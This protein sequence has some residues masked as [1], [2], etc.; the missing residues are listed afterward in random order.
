[1]KSLIAGCLAAIA[2]ALGSSFALETLQQPSAH[3]YATSSV[4]L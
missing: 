4:R 3:A 2:I 1:M